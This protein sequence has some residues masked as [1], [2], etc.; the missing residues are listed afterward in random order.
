[1]GKAKQL[2]VMNQS[3]EVQASVPTT[4][5]PGIRVKICGITNETDALACVEAG[6]HLLGFN[7]YFGSPRYIRAEVAR[8]IVEVVKEHAALVDCVGIFVNEELEDVRRIARK[9]NLDAVQLHGDESPQ[10]CVALRP[11]KVIKAL[12]VNETY[13]PRE[14]ARYPT[15]S[16]LL[17]AWRE[18][19]YGGTGQTFDWSLARATRAHVVRLLLAGGLTPENVSTAARIVQPF[20][21]DVC[22]GV[23][24]APGRK[25]IARV[26]R[27]I[28]AVRNATAE[29]EEKIGKEQSQST[30]KM[31]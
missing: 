6:A 8:G 1:M 11:L 24:S 22:G 12:R 21:V 26:R 15:E 18:D 23:E 30:K 31:K 2:E 3:P 7:F 27:F 13:D 9:T 4:S 10:Y 5:T 14:A 29:I 28:D 20:A 17:D 16:V 25:D 19:S